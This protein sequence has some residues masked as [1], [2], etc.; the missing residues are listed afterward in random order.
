MKLTDEQ[1]K[2]HKILLYVSLAAIF[3]STDIANMI[4]SYSVITDMTCI[5]YQIAIVI[6]CLIIAINSCVY[7]YTNTKTNQK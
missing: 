3:L 2:R 5:R 6:S 4:A 1:I 7:L